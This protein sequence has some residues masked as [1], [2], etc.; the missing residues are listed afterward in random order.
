MHGKSRDNTPWTLPTKIHTSAMSFS[1]PQMTL[2]LDEQLHLYYKKGKWHHM[3]YM[4]AHLRFLGQWVHNAWQG[5]ITLMVTF[6]AKQ[7]CQCPRLELISYLTEGR[8]LKW[9][10]QLVT[11]C[12]STYLKMVTHLSINNA[13]HTVTLLTSATMINLSTKISASVQQMQSC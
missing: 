9:P 11:Y 4:S 7:H 8:R 12:K 10:R 2:F 5:C 6:A 1:S 13:R 3:P